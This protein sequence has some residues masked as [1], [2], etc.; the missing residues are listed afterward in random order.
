MVTK[1]TKDKAL[2]EADLCIYNGNYQKAINIYMAV[3][4]K[5]INAP[6]AL[7]N[8]IALTLQNLYYDKSLTFLYSLERKYKKNHNLFH[9]IAK[10]LMNINDFQ[11]ALEYLNKSIDAKINIDALNDKLDC[12]RLQGQYDNAFILIDQ[13][14]TIH[15]KIL[16]DYSYNNIG[17]VYHEKNQIEEAEKYYKKAI[18][19][20]KEN[21]LPYNNIGNI[22]NSLGNKEI[23]SKYYLKTLAVEK[24]NSEAILALSFMNKLKSSDEQFKQMKS[25]LKNSN[26]TNKMIGELYISIAKVYDN[27]KEFNKSSQYLKKGRAHLKNKIKYDINDDLIK[28]DNLKKAWAQDTDNIIN[29]KK[30]KT[31]PIFILGM[32]RSGSSLLENILSTHDEING[33]GELKFLGEAVNETLLKEDIS[34]N[35]IYNNVNIWTAIGDCYLNKIQQ[36]Y[37]EQKFFID[38]MPYN[39]INIGI[40]QKAIPQSIIIDIKRN[41]KDTKLSIFQ[42]HFPEGTDYNNDISDLNAFYDIYEDIMKYWDKKY[43]NCIYN[44]DYE[45]LVYDFEKTIKL[46]MEKIGLDFT[47]NMKSFYKN[48]RITKTA[49]NIQIREPLNTKGIDKYKNYINYLPELFSE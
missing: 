6:V 23:S 19:F 49:S 17:T 34:E 35:N 24:D 40:I 30:Y 20:N 1:Y 37:G 46:I 22:Y 15:K 25:L 8:L 11:N 33:L 36:T 44:V 7:N 4:E 48:K 38:K 21:V 10:L 9:A 41:K 14:L 31:T 43:N 42:H 29:P 26:Y 47:S 18:E 16:N 5:D 3:L 13:M 12:F 39:F 45:N 32:P 2:K 27:E 28:M